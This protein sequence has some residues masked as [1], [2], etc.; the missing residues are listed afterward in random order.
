MRKKKRNRLI[1]RLEA[2]GAFDVDYLPQ[3][4]RY[5]MPDGDYKYVRT[6][7]FYRMSC[8]FCRTVTFLFGPVLCL[9]RYGLRI[10][11]RKNI[12]GI[13]GAICVC[14][15]ISVLDTLFVKQAIGHYRS[16][17]TGAPHN[18]KKG[19]GG[20]ILRRAGFLSLGGGYAAQKKLSETL[21]TLLDN[22]AVVNFYPEEALWQHYEKPRPLKTGAFRYAAKFH[23]PVIP[24][25]VTFEGRCKHAV[26]NILEPIYPTEGETDKQNAEDMCNECYAKWVEVYERVYGKPLVYDVE[27]ADKYT[28]DR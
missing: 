5:I 17:H 4:K 11:G 8:L 15:H 22:G 27:A 13:D 1:S 26:V 7:F 9:F 25:F 18:N 16:Y 24:L 3:G 23:V 21:R 19:L 6:N 12:K 2:E 14:N 28:N 20:F 10:R